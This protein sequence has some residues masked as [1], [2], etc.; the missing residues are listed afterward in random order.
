MRLTFQALV[1]LLSTLVVH[2]VQ[3]GDIFTANGNYP[4]NVGGI[5]KGLYTDS[6]K[7]LNNDGNSIMMINK[8]TKLSTK[9]EEELN[10]END[11]N[12]ESK[13][14]HN[15]NKNKGHKDKKDKSKNKNNSNSK[16][17]DEQ[18]VQYHM[19]DSDFTHAKIYFLN[20]KQQE[21]VITLNHGLY[22]D[23]NGLLWLASHNFTYNLDN[24]LIYFNRY[25][26]VDIMTIKYV[27]L[28]QKIKRMI[29]YDESKNDKVEN[30][31]TSTIAM[32]DNKI[33][34][35]IS[36][37]NSN[38]TSNMIKS[39][40]TSDV[41][42]P[43]TNT[44]DKNNGNNNNNKNKKSKNKVTTT[45][46]QHIIEE[47]PHCPLFLVLKFDASN[48]YTF[49]PQK[50]EL[51]SKLKHKK[52]VETNKLKQEEEK[53]KE[54]A[55]DDNIHAPLV[56]SNLSLH[57]SSSN[58]GSINSNKIIAEIISTTSTSTPKSNVLEFN[59]D[60]KA[61][62]M[63]AHLYSL[64]SYFHFHSDHILS[65]KNL[66]LSGRDIELFGNSYPNLYQ[67]YRV[68]TQ[69]DEMQNISKTSPLALHPDYYQSIKSSNSNSNSDTSNTNSNNNNE[70]SKS[71]GHSTFSIFRGSHITLPSSKDK[72]K[73]KNKD[74]K[75]K[76]KDKDKDS[77]K[78]LTPDEIPL[79]TQS[80]LAQMYNKYEFDTRMEYFS[81]LDESRV[82]RSFQ[83]YGGITFLIFVIYSWNLFKQF[84][85]SLRNGGSASANFAKLSLCTIF[86]QFIYLGVIIMLHIYILFY[87]N[88]DNS[89]I[90][91]F[92]LFL[93]TMAFVLSNIYNHIINHAWRHRE[94]NWRYFSYSARWLLGI[95]I[96]CIFIIIGIS[97][98]FKD[99]MMVFID[100]NSESNGKNEINYFKNYDSTHRDLFSWI[101]AFF[102]G[103]SN[104][105]DNN[106]NGDP[107][108]SN[109]TKNDGLFHYLFNG[110]TPSMIVMIIFF[111]DYISQIIENMISGEKKAW[112][113]RC[114]IMISL[115]RIYFPLYIFGCPFNI[116]QN[117]PNVLFCL[118][119]ILMTILQIY[120]LNKQDKLGARWLIP[121]FL[122]PKGYEYHRA[123]SVPV[124]SSDE[125]YDTDDIDRDRDRDRDHDSSLLDDDDEDNDNDDD[126]DIDEETSSLLATTSN[127]SNSE[128]IERM[129]G[130]GGGDNGGDNDNDKD[131]DEPIDVIISRNGTNGGSIEI[132]TLL[133]PHDNGIMRHRG[134]FGGNNEDGSYNEKLKNKNKTKSKSKKRKKRRKRRK[135]NE[136]ITGDS[137]IIGNKKKKKAKDSSFDLSSMGS[138]GCSADN[139][140][141]NNNNKG[142]DS[143]DID[144][145][146]DKKSNSNKKKK[147]RKRG[148]S[149]SI[150]CAVCFE[151][152]VNNDPSVMI[153]PCQHYFHDRCLLPWMETRLSCPTCR[154][155]LP[156]ID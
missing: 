28:N 82:L 151:K 136:E 75:D 17:D 81:I 134:K 130:N 68:C 30:S 9:H 120:I 98:Y 106:N 129:I 22:D 146:I 122:K 114:C 80:R 65:S 35:T 10:N 54:T 126:D 53:F 39:N 91:N 89:L 138:I 107:S 116:L 150:Q 117:N 19:F 95:R 88:F 141:I 72:N 123:Y 99:N 97:W 84:H 154:T 61:K 36:N 94:S 108:D 45:K 87:I 113:I 85:F 110:F 1:S 4:D 83:N 32:S 118:I 78:K 104:T 148:E 140:N 93:S 60:P 7:F 13:D 21:R 145:D 143:N 42:S 139:N 156:A 49:I 6:A 132:G 46:K 76:D 48:N 26:I 50:E 153:T 79:E 124:D 115:C 119:L 40:T 96:C 23:Y 37:S 25:S 142:K 100:S 57:N 135:M 41:T 52:R 3:D 29:D 24:Q 64:N 69:M 109:S 56:L 5:Y 11:K 16:N 8:I 103:D 125:D 12:S 121:K 105:N 133:E 147:K 102:V 59:S 43:Q 112:S 20:K 90:T 92:F 63:I 137:G 51:F 55:N 18:K 127:N 149:K 34:N 131:K 2:S 73:N 70:E 58:S 86:M 15:K 38:S 101:K 67:F 31:N 144:F 128:E 44:K 155:K 77:G 27:L 152:I 111:S 74:K 47:L 66:T 71:K 33:N 62:H 14:S